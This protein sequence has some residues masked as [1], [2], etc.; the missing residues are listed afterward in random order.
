M[1][2]Q[3]PQTLVAGFLQAAHCFDDASGDILNFQIAEKFIMG[4]RSLT[5]GNEQKISETSLGW[6]P[7]KVR[8]AYG[9]GRKR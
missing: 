1:S 4:C 7:C 3:L 5:S 2:L 6:V 8:I 9:K